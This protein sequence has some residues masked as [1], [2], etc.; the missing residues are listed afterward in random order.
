MEG[1]V[2]GTQACQTGPFLSISVSTL[3]SSIIRSQLVPGFCRNFSTDSNVV[4]MI[5]IVGGEW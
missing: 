4:D 2:G 3:L 5:S 1:R